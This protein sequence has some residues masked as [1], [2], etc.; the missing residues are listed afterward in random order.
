[1]VQR[2]LS[3]A[4]S[5]RPDR[6]AVLV[7][8]LGATPL[9]ELL[10]VYRAVV[11]LL[12]RAGLTSPAAMSGTSR[13]RWKWPGARSPCWTSIEELERGSPRP[14]LS[15]LAALTAVLTSQDL[16]TAIQRIHRRID[17]IRDRLNAA[18]ARLGDGDT[19]MTV[20]TLVEAVHAASGALPEDVGAALAVWG[21]ECRQ[22]SGS[23]LAAVVAIG[24]S[25]AARTLAGRVAVDRTGIAGALE[26]AAEAITERSGA[27]A[28]DKTMLDSLLRIGTRSGPAMDRRPL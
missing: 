9:E 4:P 2:L 25:R 20:A 7:N 18:D 5:D 28:G 14:P 23:S 24:L 17:S 11:P 1:M 10:I 6:V 26:R 16:G 22:A 19:G 13:H 27:T 15:V 3:D 8:S 21:R 12:D